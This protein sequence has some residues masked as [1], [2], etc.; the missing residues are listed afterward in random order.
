MPSHFEVDGKRVHYEE[1]LAAY[2]QDLLS[3]LVVTPGKLVSYLV[4]VQVVLLRFQL[5]T[6]INQKYSISLVVHHRA[7]GPRSL[8]HHSGAGERYPTLLL[9]SYLWGTDKSVL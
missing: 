3:T 5:F 1:R 4:S 9:G 8:L 6:I 7:P 2:L